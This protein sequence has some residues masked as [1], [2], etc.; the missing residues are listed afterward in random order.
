MITI[1][2]QAR[3][4]Y[5]RLDSLHRRLRQARDPETRDNLRADLARVR[6][7]IA[8]MDGKPKARVRPD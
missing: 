7:M 6:D 2:E 3:K 8:E 1:P 4:L 5:L